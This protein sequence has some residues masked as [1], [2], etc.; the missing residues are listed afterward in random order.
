MGFHD[1]SLTQDEAHIKEHLKDE[2]DVTKKMTPQELEFHYFRLHDT[3]NDTKLDGLEIMSALSHIQ[4]MFEI[5]PHEK[6]GKTEAEIQKLQAERKAGSLQYFAD[7]IDNV[8]KD[9][10]F[11]HDGYISYPEYMSARKPGK[12]TKKQRRLPIALNFHA[13]CV[14]IET[15]SR[16]E[17]C[18]F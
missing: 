11:N 9:D 4:H 17:K 8:L 6:Q 18:I 12:F 1:T 14:N 16:V 15:D 13:A 3:N 10:D 7:V 5:Q 2:I